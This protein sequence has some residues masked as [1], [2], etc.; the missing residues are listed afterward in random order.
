MQSQSLKMF[1]R[2][3][4]Q[5][6]PVFWQDSRVSAS[7]SDRFLEKNVLR[8]GISLCTQV[9]VWSCELS[10][11]LGVTFRRPEDKVNN[12]LGRWELGASHGPAACTAPG[13][14]LATAGTEEGRGE[15]WQRNIDFQKS[16]ETFSQKHLLP[17]STYHQQQGNC[18]NDL[19]LFLFPHS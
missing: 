6:F 17:S 13:P 12:C 14:S 2:H 3:S 11:S 7:C 5:N 18:I 1:S 9:P 19:S 4:R 16:F 15:D 10:V 8:Q